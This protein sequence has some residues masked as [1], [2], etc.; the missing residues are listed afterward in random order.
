MLI[1]GMRHWMVATVGRGRV[2]VTVQRVFE[3]LDPS[4]LSLLAVFLLLAARDADRPLVIHPPCSSQLSADENGLAR[5]VA[6][7]GDSY[8]AQRCLAALGCAASGALLRTLAALAERF[9]AGGL[10][11]A[12]APQ[13]VRGPARRAARL[14]DEEQGF[15]IETTRVRAATSL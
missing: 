5:A 2:P 10:A 11:V 12:V 14:V 4:S 1:W 9:R 7:A 15:E 6:L 13:A 3:L 8:A